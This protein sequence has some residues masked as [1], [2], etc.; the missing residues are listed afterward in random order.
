MMFVIILQ[1]FRRLRDTY[2]FRSKRVPCHFPVQFNIGKSG[3]TNK[4][5]EMVDMVV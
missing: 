1:P 4:L 3:H 2:L 5:P